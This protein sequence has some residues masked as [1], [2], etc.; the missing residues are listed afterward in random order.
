VLTREVLDGTGIEAQLLTPPED[1]SGPSGQTEPVERKVLKKTENTLFG[2]EIRQNRDIIIS[3]TRS[4][5]HLSSA[6]GK[7]RLLILA[8]ESK[9]ARPR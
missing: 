7:D 9:C 1:Q 6:I 3:W 4:T 5:A 8:D 2:F